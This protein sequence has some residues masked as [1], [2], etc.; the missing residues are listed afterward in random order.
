MN[1]SD[2]FPSFCS[3]YFPGIRVEQCQS[4]TGAAPEQ[5]L[6]LVCTL[7]T[8]M[9]ALPHSNTPPETINDTVDHH[10]HAVSDVGR[11]AIEIAGCNGHVPRVSF[12]H[13]SDRTDHLLASWVLCKLVCV[14]LAPSY[15]NVHI[16][17]VRYHFSLF[18][19]HQTMS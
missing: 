19:R 16:Q 14:L 9:Q 8:H 1:Q 3:N 11:Y 2:P 15:E 7:Q 6:D 13:P 12:R 5:S 17:I 18:I 4:A 10:R